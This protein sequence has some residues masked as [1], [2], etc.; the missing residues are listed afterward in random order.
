MSAITRIVA[1]Q[2][3]VKRLGPLMEVAGMAV[4]IAGANADLDDPFAWALRRVG[5]TTAAVNTT[6]DAELALLASTK[7]DD[8]LDLAEYRTLKNILG[9]LDAVDVV[10]G[11]RAEKL[12]QYADKVKAM[13][14]RL[15]TT[16]V[17]ATTIKPT[18]TGGYV[19]LDFIE[20]D[21]A[22]IQ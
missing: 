20:H 12:S 19:T 5:G 21:D 4:T 10:T 14:A 22:V 8:F 11:P 13:L 9:A 16:G 1:A 15:E 6:T 18:L 3:I 7:Y 2:V 17:V